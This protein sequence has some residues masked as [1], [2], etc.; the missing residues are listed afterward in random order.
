MAKK[1]EK[2]PAFIIKNRLTEAKHGVTMER[3]QDLVK[4]QE[5]EDGGSNKLAKEAL[6]EAA[7]EEAD[8]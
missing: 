6:K 4:R 1:K 2:K 7:E 5:Y 8:E 3:Y